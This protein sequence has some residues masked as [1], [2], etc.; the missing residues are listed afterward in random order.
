[1]APLKA[2]ITDFDYGD[3][4]IERGILEPAGVEVIALQA[5]SEDDLLAA[6]GDCDAMMNQ[7]ARVGARTIAAMTRCKVIARYGVGVDIVDIEAATKRGIV[8]TNVRDYCTEEVA[9]HA[10]A[11]WLTLARKLPQNDRATHQGIWR[12]QS[13]SPINRIRGQVMGIVSF[14]KIGQAIARRAEAFG[15][16]LIVY[17]PYQQEAVIAAFGAKK[18]SKEELL[19]RS[20]IMMMQVPMTPETRHFLSV[21]EFSAMQHGVIIVNTGRG[22]TMDNKALYAALRSGTV[23]GA[24]LDDPEEEP[25]KRAK[26]SP[27]ENPLFSLANVIVTPHAAYYSEQSIRLA[28]ETAASEVRRVLTGERPLHAVNNVRLANGEMSISGN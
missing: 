4:A 1:M 6:A 2:V 3:V 25:A 26:W 11:L 28:R 21:K 5:K 24:G 23:A 22:P 27:G 18:V 15:V 9:D 7:Y 13:G 12:W 20:N 14:G 19:S 8:V 16:E 17:D 10:I